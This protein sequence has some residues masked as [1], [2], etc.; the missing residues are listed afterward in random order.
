MSGG[1]QI[2]EN[3]IRLGSHKGVHLLKLEGAKSSA[4]VHGGQSASSFSLFNKAL[5]IKLEN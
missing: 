1:G 4:S 2:S 3:K 5:T